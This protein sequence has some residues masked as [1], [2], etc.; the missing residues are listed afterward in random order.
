MWSKGHYGLPRP[1]SFNNVFLSKVY[2]SMLRPT[3]SNCV[4]SPSAKMACHA[5]CHLTVCVVQGLLCHSTPDVVRPCVKSK[6]NDGI[7]CSKFFNCVCF[8]NAMMECQAGRYSTVLAFQ[9]RRCHATPDVVRSCLLSKGVDVMPR[10]TSFDHVCCPKAMI[11]CHARRS[12]TVCA[13]QR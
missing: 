7:P 3:S 8:L 2:E 9:G 4:C 10:P 11:A 5:L 1:P 12:S 13:A 6:G